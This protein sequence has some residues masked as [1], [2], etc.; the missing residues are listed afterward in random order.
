ME[1]SLVNTQGFH[2]VLVLAPHTDDGEF[3]CGGT[4]ARLIRQGSEVWYVAFSAAEKSVPPGHPDDILQH[5]VK[6]AT[7]VLGL[8]PENLTILNYPVRDFPLHRQKILEDL[9]KMQR[10]FQPNAVF[11]PST[12]DTHQDHQVISSEGF[13]AFKRTTLLGYELPWN[14]LTFSTNAFVLLDQVDLDIKLR[15]LACYD[16]QKGRPYADPD[17]ITGLARTRGVQIG[18]PYAEAFEIIRSVFY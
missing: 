16:S 6:R 7:A 14:N 1:E 5:E 17:F 4:I 2:R 15:A 12:H 11:I 13:R 18:H 8:R 3:G 9:I 10:E